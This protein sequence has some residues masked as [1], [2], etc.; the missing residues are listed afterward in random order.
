MFEFKTFHDGFYMWSWNQKFQSGHYLY[1]KRIILGCQLFREKLDRQQYGLFSPPPP[2]CSWLARPDAQCYALRILCAVRPV[3]ACAY[4]M[5]PAR[6]VGQYVVVVTR[7]LPETSFLTQYFPFAGHCGNSLWKHKNYRILPRWETV[8]LLYKHC[9]LGF[10]G[11]AALLVLNGICCYKKNHIS[12][13]NSILD[14]AG[15]IMVFTY[16]FLCYYTWNIHM[17]SV[18]KLGGF[19]VM[20]PS[21]PAWSLHL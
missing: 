5:A 2:S 14:K 11:C 21:I 6:L 18:M 9:I 12:C 15:W 17:W 7:P 16:V 4:H 8:W 3:S 1:E 10:A 19:H 20:V 13:F